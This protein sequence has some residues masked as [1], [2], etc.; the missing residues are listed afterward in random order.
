MVAGKDVETIRLT[1]PNDSAAMLPG[2]YVEG[3][4]T[5][6]VQDDGYDAEEHDEPGR[7]SFIGTLMHDFQLEV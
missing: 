1:Q 3:C 4:K 6:T 7:S 5:Y 2:L